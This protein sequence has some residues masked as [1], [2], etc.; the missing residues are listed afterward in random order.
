MVYTT[1]ENYIRDFL[2]AVAF[3]D[4][5]KLIELLPMDEVPNNKEDITQITDMLPYA[6][7]STIECNL[8]DVYH[9]LDVNLPHLSSL[10]FLTAAQLN[11]SKT[12]VFLAPL[13]SK[14][15]VST[16]I[17]VIADGNIK[18]GLIKFASMEARSFELI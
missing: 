7:I 5:E 10:A 12:V 14:Q 6:M 2:K 16:T 11:Y 8:T 15:I 4:M 3:Q 18:R 9:L 13:M 17:K 1:V